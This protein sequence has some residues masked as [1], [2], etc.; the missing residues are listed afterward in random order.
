MCTSLCYLSVAAILCELTTMQHSLMHLQSVKIKLTSTVDASEA[1]WTIAYTSRLIQCSIILTYS[2]TN[3]V[4][5][6]LIQSFAI[7]TFIRT[8]IQNSHCS[9]FSFHNPRWKLGRIEN[10]SEHLS[11]L[12]GRLSVI[13]EGDI[14]GYSIVIT[15]KGNRES[16]SDVVCSIYNIHQGE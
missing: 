12:L 10:D 7:W 14:E 1:N 6:R 11:V 16:S 3:A 13:D 2:C 8:V 4:T 5:R 9:R 15:W